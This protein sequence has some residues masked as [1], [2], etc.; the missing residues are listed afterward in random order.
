MLQTALFSFNSQK[1]FIMTIKK[2]LILTNCITI[3]ALGYLVYKKLMLYATENKLDYID[4]N[5]TLTTSAE[6][7]LS[8]SFSVDGTHFNE[9][10]YTIWATAIKTTL[11]KY[12][13]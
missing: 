9:N 4:L 13:I 12:N 5:P 8:D 10:T 6:Q 1:R 2:I 11:L 3:L 7:S